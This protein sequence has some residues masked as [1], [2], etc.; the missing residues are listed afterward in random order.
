MKF[1]KIIL[2]HGPTSCKEVK[3]IY[4][5]VIELENKPGCQVTYS[6]DLQNSPG[7]I[8]VGA[9]NETERKGKVSVVFMIK[10]NDFFDLLD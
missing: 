3:G 7:K 5:F 8:Y 9:W 1:H 4:E 2:E 10:E 6:M